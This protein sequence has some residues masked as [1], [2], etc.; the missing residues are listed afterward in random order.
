VQKIDHGAEH[1]GQREQQDG[2]GLC[3]PSRRHNPH[4]YEN[5]RDPEVASGLST[6][7]ADAWGLTGTRATT[8]ATS[9]G[10]RNRFASRPSSRTD[11][12]EDAEGFLGQ[13]PRVTTVIANMATL[14]AMHDPAR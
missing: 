13:P 3:G 12:R 8:R 14:P 10:C 11:E 4:N 7:A 1:V 6:I 9:V 2:D 5:C